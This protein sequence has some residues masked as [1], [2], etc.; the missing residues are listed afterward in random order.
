[1]FDHY[2]GT[3]S[4][5]NGFNTASPIFQQAGWI[6][7][8][9]TVDPSGVTLPPEGRYPNRDWGPMHT[10]GNNGAMNGAAA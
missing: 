2:F 9:Q 10:S 3:L 1:M 7:K 4:G 8:T 6:P 5:T